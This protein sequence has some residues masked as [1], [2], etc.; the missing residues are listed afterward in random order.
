MLLH[1][2]AVGEQCPQRSLD[3]DLVQGREAAG[4]HLQDEGLELS[5]NKDSQC[6]EKAPNKALLS[7]KD[8]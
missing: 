4:R 8:P 2:Q 7:K 1:S 3:R 6:L 5:T